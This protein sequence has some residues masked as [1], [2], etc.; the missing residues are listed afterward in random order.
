MA[1]QANRL[2]VDPLELVLEEVVRELATVGAEGVR[3]DQLGTGVHEAHVERDDGV[4][5]AQVRLLCATQT[6]NCGGEK[7]AHTAVGDDRRT[8]LQPFE[9]A[10]HGASVVKR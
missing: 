1:R 10:A 3:L 4:R 2:G 8:A 6:R 5:R 9:E 7:G